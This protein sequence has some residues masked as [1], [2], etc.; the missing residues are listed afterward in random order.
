MVRYFILIKRKSGKNWLGAIP[1][2][3]NVSL[4]QLRKIKTKPSFVKKIVTESELKRILS[5]LVPKKQRVRTVT[6]KKKRVVRRKPQRR[7]R[8]KVT[9]KRIVKKK[10]R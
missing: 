3:K 5:K 7:V 1:A 6:R 10:R 2:K 4:A 8:R 9:R